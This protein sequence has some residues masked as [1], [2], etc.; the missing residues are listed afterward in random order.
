MVRDVAD[1]TNLKDSSSYT[2]YMKCFYCLN[3]QNIVMDQKENKKRTNF[4][5]DIDEPIIGSREKRPRNK[6]NNNVQATS[7]DSLSH[8][9]VKESP[10]IWD[11]S[12]KVAIDNS[13]KGYH[14]R[15]KKCIQ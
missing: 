1:I 10:S 5:A 4:Q 2:K 11:A 13:G 15:T 8:V 9:T 7:D 6:S 14:N 12:I 3:E